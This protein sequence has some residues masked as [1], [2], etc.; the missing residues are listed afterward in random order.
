VRDVPKAVAFYDKVMAALGIKRVMEFMPYAVAYGA[1]LP[2]FW[3]QLP[4]DQKPA[5]VGNG[6]HFCFNATSESAVQAFHA[7]ALKAGGS[8]DGAPG[9]RP[10]Y[11]PNYYGA[12][13][14]DLDGNK[15]E[16]V[17]FIPSA[18]AKAKPK[19]KAAAKKKPAAKSKAKPG[20][21]K[22]K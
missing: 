4:H 6:A 9:P 1:A 22:R 21:R 13:V 15:I 11:A 18:K 10:D 17:F 8:D 5:S 14:R 7:A 16:A 3:V 2:E 19:P 20:A 12:F